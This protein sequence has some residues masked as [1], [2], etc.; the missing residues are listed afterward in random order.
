M[1]ILA[2]PPD[3]EF[4]NSHLVWFAQRLVKYRQLH[5]LLEVVCADPRVQWAVR[6]DLAPPKTQAGWNGAPALPAVVTICLAVIRRLMGWG[7]R[8]VADEVS[9]NAGW[10][11]V[12]QL[13][14]EPMPNFRTIRDREAKLRPRTLQLINQVVVEVAGRL[15]V[16]A[17]QKLRVDSSVTETDIHFPTD[18]SLLDDAARVL[19]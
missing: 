1:Y 17:G 4:L 11:W 2:Y 3:P 19:S 12:C 5:D 9:T 6:R 18:S 13:Y 15:G 7:Y 8:T 10:R 16:T 14:N